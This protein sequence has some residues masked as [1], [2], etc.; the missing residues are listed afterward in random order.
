MTTSRH[1]E[2][3]VYYYRG[4]IETGHMYG[5]WSPGYSETTCEGNALYPRQTCRD[6]KAVFVD[7]KLP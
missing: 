6:C 7:T 2:T 3:V 5:T 1:R 4:L